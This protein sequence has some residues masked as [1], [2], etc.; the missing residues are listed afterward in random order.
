ML[1]LSIQE[2]ESL[3][4]DIFKKELVKL[5]NSDQESPELVESTIH[6]Y[7]TS[8]IYNHKLGGRYTTECLISLDKLI[9]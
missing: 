8:I 4:L 6:I 9:S 1:N 2:A 7:L 3:W 5:L